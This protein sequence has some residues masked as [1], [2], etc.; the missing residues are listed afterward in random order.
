MEYKHFSHSFICLLET[1]V[2][3]VAQVSFGLHMWL[4]QANGLE[5]FCVSVSVW[6]GTEST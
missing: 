2:H 1:R 5:P 3:N 4:G 6:D